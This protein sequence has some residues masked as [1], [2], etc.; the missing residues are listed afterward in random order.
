M[1]PEPRLEMENTGYSLAALI[2][3][4]SVLGQYSACLG[5]CED[6]GDDGGHKG[7]NADY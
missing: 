2:A 5:Y 1:E 6:E 7:G 3:D 4:P